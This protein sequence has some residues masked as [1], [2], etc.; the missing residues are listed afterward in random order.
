MSRVNFDDIRAFED[1]DVKAALGR[2]LDEPAFLKAVQFIFPQWTKPVLEEVFSKIESIRDFQSSVIYSVVQQ[3]LQ[4]SVTELSF[5]GLENLR[6]DSAYLFISN[7]RDIILDSAFLN[8]LM[9]ENQFDTTRIA[10]GN[11]LLIYPWITD[12]VRLNR[13]FVVKRD[14]PRNEMVEASRKLSA[15]IR[16]SIAEQGVS[17][18]IAQREG[19]AKDGNDRTHPGLIKMLGISGDGSFYD[20]YKA[21]NL[22]PL[23]ISYEFDPCDGLKTAELIGKANLVF[24]KSEKD[25]LISMYTGLVGKK[26]RVHYAFNILP[27]QEIQRVAEIQNKNDQMKSM[28]EL[29]DGV[30]IGNYRLWPTNFIAFDLLQG[31]NK[32][33]NEYTRQE[34]DFFVEYMNEKLKII[35]EYGEQ[36]RTVFLE[37]YANPV[38]NKLALNSL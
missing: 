27:E 6:R 5:S 15:Y 16:Y 22:A 19:R 37:M 13:S 33:E 2:L 14:L 11:N 4:R 21:I 1:R 3:I 23:S 34:R 35:P 17:V 12:V 26:G 28:A 25:D 20:N 36:A 8:N 31:E 10:I 9:Y 30:I 7:H 32:F 18:W 38:K 29:I 24:K